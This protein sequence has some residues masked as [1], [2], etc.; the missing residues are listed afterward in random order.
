MF[1]LPTVEKDGA[2]VGPSKEGIVDYVPAANGGDSS[3][4]CLSVTLSAAHSAGPIAP[5]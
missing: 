1:L 3:T 5:T 2:F 4:R